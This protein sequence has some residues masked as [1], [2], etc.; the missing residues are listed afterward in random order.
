MRT[1]PA[2]VV[3]VFSIASVA[4]QQPAAP[5]FDVVSIKENLSGQ[6]GGGATP[7]RNG[8]WQATNLALKSLIGVAWSI[9]S[10]RVFDAPD[11]TSVTRYD[12][13]GVTAADATQAQLQSMLQG[14]LRDRFAVRVHVEQRDLPTYNLVLA[15]SDGRLGPAVRL[16]PIRDCLDRAAIAAMTPAPR[17]CMM[18]FGSG[19]LGGTMTVANLAATLTGAS[20][21]PVFDRTGLTGNYELDLKWTPTLA[22]DAGPE[23]VSIF[24]ALQEQLGLKLEPA[25]APLD[26]L[27]VDGVDRPT[28][29]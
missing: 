22:G 2:L 20:G 19:T 4:G 27:I 28:A 21:R 24:T 10:S 14:L 18:Q 5:A 26:V 9:P 16:S 3:G 15:R 23:T 29:N 12:I 13:T 7:L 8:R 11:W 25:S 17:P 1:I 6:D